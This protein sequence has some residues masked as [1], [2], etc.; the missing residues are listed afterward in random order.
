MTAF[1]L[2]LLPSSP[3]SLNERPI[4][5]VNIYL[6]SGTKKVYLLRNARRALLSTHFLSYLSVAVN[7][8]H[9]KVALA[10]EFLTFPLT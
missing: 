10:G 2:A 9:P 4:E 8:Q 3:L 1:V 5:G 6:E 7:K